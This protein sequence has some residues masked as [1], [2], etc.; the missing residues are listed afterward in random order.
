MSFIQKLSPILV[1]LALLA[2]EQAARADIIRYSFDAAYNRTT[3]LGGGTSTTVPDV[4]PDL[5]ASVQQ[6]S[7]HG[8]FSIDTAAPPTGA[9]VGPGS[10]EYLGAL[11]V[12]MASSTGLEGTTN[13]NL[14][15]APP[16]IFG[17]SDQL[18]FSGHGRDVPGWTLVEAALRWACCDQLDLTSTSLQDLP[19]FTTASFGTF[20]QPAAGSR[21]RS[22]DVGFVLDNDSNDE[23][24][25]LVY[26]ID[27]LNYLGRVAVPEPGTLALLAGGLAGFGWLRRRRRE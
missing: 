24:A 25:L 23:E 18:S 10:V 5:P 6:G 11:T 14:V 9:D 4:S 15:I 1:V 8:M 3:L 16:G 19:V 2:G 13:G 22:G 20:V 26:H 12:S 21:L 17:I 27:E 7:V